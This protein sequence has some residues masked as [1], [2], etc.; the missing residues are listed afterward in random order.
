MKKIK[1]QALLL[2]I[3]MI[4]SCFFGCTGS[5]AGANDAQSSAQ[6]SEESVRTES[7]STSSN[8][9][10]TNDPDGR[11]YFVES[12]IDRL[13]DPF[14][15]V[16]NGKYYVYGTGWNCYKSV[17]GRLDGSFMKLSNIVTRPDDAQKDFW[18]PEV[19]KYNDAFYMFTTYYSSKTQHRGCAVFRSDIPEGPFELVSDGH[20]TPSDWD[21]ID[22]SLYIDP[23]GQPWM[24]FVHEWTS[25]PDSVGAMAAAKL[26]DDLSHFISEPIQLFRASDAPWAKS[27]VTDGCFMYT[28]SNGELLML[29]SSFS[30]SGYCVGVARSDNGRLDGNWTHDKEP[31]YSKSVSGVYDGGHPMLF[32]SI[33]GHLYMAMHSPNSADG[34][35]KE[36]P[37]FVPFA[38]ADGKITLD[39]TKRQY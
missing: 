33:E 36:K 18:A 39:L 15:L 31:L 9:K 20:V 28:A 11:V 30:E 35:R 26:S 5:G 22:G 3:V 37:V 12:L 34:A 1:L 19:Y 7:E 6:T 13:R 24:V 16:H 4:S 29:W 27:G 25:M 8:N 10:N 2:L 14:V 23:D 21:A 38:E 32:T 17:M